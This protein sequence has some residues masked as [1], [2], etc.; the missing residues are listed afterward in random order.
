[1]LT[2]SYTLLVLPVIIFFINLFIINFI[3]FRLQRTITERTVV[4]ATVVTVQ[5][6]FKTSMLLLHLLGALFGRDIYNKYLLAKG[7]VPLYY[8]LIYQHLN[9]Y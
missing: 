1:M 9:I 4:M 6:A 2:V 3:F 7:D 8:Y 5:N